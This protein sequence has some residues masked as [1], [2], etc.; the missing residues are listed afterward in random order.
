MFWVPE[1]CLFAQKIV[2]SCGKAQLKRIWK[3]RIYKNLQGT[4]RIFHW[5][6]SIPRKRED[7][8]VEISV[9][10]ATFPV[11][12]SP[13]RATFWRPLF[14]KLWSLNDIERSRK[15]HAAFKF[16]IIRDSTNRKCSS[17]CYGLTPIGLPQLPG[18]RRGTCSHNFMLSRRPEGLDPMEKETIISSSNNFSRACSYLLLET[19]GIW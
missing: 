3:V 14:P 9:C 15:L 7:Q 18:K 13:A 17:D 4:A 2:Q 5:I 6:G 12:N 11:Q 8:N 19:V 16:W 10:V 1:H